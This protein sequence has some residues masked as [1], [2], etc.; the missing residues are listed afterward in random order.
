MKLLNV[1]RT[2]KM[3]H[4]VKGETSIDTDHMVSLTMD[5]EENNQNF[6]AATMKVFQEL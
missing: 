4:T 5:L 2:K 1:D 3:W 6:K